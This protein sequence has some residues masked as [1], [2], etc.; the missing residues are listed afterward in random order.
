MKKIKNQYQAIAYG[1][2]QNVNYIMQ[3]KKVRILIQAA[4]NIVQ[5]LLPEFFSV[6]EYEPYF[7][8]LLEEMKTLLICLSFRIGN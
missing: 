6:E 1:A 8:K 3:K 2:N 5:N 7:S 4:R